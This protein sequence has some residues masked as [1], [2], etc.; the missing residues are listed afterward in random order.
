MD[1]GT[2]KY[3]SFTVIYTVRTMSGPLCDGLHVCPPV[4]ALGQPPLKNTAFGIESPASLTCSFLPRADS[5]LTITQ[6][7]RNQDM[8]PQAKN[9][10]NCL[11]AKHGGEVAQTV[12]IGVIVNLGRF[13][14]HPN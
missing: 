9:A 4:R 12:T 11:P 3:G 2:A 5:P 6:L 14:V 10:K 13:Q 1:L 7:G 8:E